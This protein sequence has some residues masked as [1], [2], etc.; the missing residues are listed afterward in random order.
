MLNPA[1]KERL[2]E[3]LDR[4]ERLYLQ[5]GSMVSLGGRLFCSHGE[6]KALMREVRNL[7]EIAGGVWAKVRQP[8]PPPA[9]RA[10]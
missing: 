4:G 7:R 10:F 9:R 1:E 2:Y 8:S 5:V 3:A 6:V